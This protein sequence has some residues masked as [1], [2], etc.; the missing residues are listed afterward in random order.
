M[1]GA[2]AV[3]TRSVQPLSIVVGNPAKIAGYLDGDDRRVARRHGFGFASPSVRKVAGVSLRPLT[4]RADMR[5]KVAVAEEGMELPFIPRRVFMVYDVPSIEVRGEH[6]H[7]A[8]EQFLVCARGR[9]TVGVDDGRGR[10]EYLLDRPT[11]GLYIPPR[12]WSDQYQYSE[13][14]V[15]VVAASLPYDPDDYIREYGEYVEFVG[16]VGTEG[17]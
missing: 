16:A 6:A 7:R 17:V 4:A 1:V 14:A 3:V 8:C 15:L 5:G 11:M 12:V 2:G 10:D 13:D 9:V